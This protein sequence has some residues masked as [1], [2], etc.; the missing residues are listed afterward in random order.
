MK[1]LTHIF[2]DNFKRQNQAKHI[3]SLLQKAKAIPLKLYCKISLNIENH[4]FLNIKYNYF[5]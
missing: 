2:N 1:K 5:I 4:N 3:Q